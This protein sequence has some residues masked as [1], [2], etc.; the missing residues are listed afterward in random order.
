MA[1]IVK[2][3]EERRIELINAAECLFIEKGF[4]QTL[5][6]DIVKRLGVA[7]GTFY[8]YFKSKDEI[9]NAILEIKWEQL[10][11]QISKILDTVTGPLQKLQTLFEMLFNSENDMIE[12]SSFKMIEDKTILKRFHQQFDEARIKKLK[13]LILSIVNEGIKEKIFKDIRYV[14]EVVEIIFFGINMFIHVY[15][16]QFSDYNIYASKMAGLEE[17]MEIVLGLD[18]GSFCFTKPKGENK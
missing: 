10:T 3:P 5:I 14:D 7:Q 4:D 6:S 11:E 17:T 15:H 13:P 8:Y 16:P 18:K 2:D 12:A 9:L 1:R